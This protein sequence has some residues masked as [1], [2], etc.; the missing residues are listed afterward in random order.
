M[1]PQ[2]VAWWCL[3]VNSR[4][5]LAT[6]HQTL[7]RAPAPELRF[8]LIVGGVC[9][10]RGQEGGRIAVPGSHQSRQDHEFGAQ[11]KRNTTAGKKM[12]GV[13][14]SFAAK[15]ASRTESGSSVLV[16]VVSVQRKK[17]ARKSAT[18]S[19][20]SD[21]K[22]KL[23]VFCTSRDRA[24]A[25]PVCAFVCSHEPHRLVLLNSVQPEAWLTDFLRPAP[26]SILGRSA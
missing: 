25:H 21:P 8:G 16:S 22:N 14:Q 23:R 11:T 26:W 17:A 7:T 19:S 6:W 5:Y 10:G 20:C 9:C 2:R 4:W 1:Q 18:A 3:G 12:K 15:A 24:P 13:G